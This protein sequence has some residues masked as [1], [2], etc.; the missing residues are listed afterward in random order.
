[1][2]NKNSQTPVPL[3]DTPLID[4]SFNHVA[5]DLIGL[6]IPASLRGHLY[7]LTVHFV[8]RYPEAIMLCKTDTVTIAEADLDSMGLHGD[9]PQSVI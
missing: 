6:I 9:S 2:T 1:M 4:T 8:M 5:I 7:T 3:G